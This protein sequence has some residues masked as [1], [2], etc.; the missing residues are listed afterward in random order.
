MSDASEI[1]WC[2]RFMDARQAEIGHEAVV[3]HNW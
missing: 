3:R 2:R 1:Q